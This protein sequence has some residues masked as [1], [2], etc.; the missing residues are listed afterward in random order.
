ML[1]DVS[2]K[3]ASTLDLPLLLEMISGAT[4][5]GRGL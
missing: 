4:P 1:L 2:A 3:L 5:A